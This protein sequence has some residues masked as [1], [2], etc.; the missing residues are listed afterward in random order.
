MKRYPQG[1]L[2]VKVADKH[3]LDGNEPVARAVSDAAAEL[4]D[5][6]RILVRPS[7]TEPVVRVMVEAAD[8]ETARR[9]ADAVA[10]VVE[11]EL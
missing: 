6:G 9:Y 7:G 8:L 5:N 1:L 2:N 3:A 10:K 4:G 11:A